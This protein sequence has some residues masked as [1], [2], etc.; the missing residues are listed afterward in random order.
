MRVTTDFWISSLMRRV[1]SGGG[2][3]AIVRRG[4][5][6][7]G[8]VFFILRGRGG[9]LTLYGPAAQAAYDAARPDDRR[10]GL[11]MTAAS[12][13]AL[14]ERLAREQRFDSDV[15]VVELEL[16]AQPLETLITVS[17]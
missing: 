4:S 13:D 2:F 6:E 9:E 1:F 12:E 11:V 8:A 17:V 7:A 10:F 14:A 16:G 5:A 3:A 15:W